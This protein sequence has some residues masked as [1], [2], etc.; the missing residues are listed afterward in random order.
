MKGC[1]N[2]DNLEGNIDPSAIIK[3]TSKEL[4]K[5]IEDSIKIYNNANPESKL[6]LNKEKE[7]KDVDNVFVCLYNDNKVGLFKKYTW[8]QRSDACQNENDLK[9]DE[10]DIY[11]G[12]DSNY[13]GVQRTIYAGLEFARWKNNGFKVNYDGIAYIANCNMENSMSFDDMRHIMYNDKKIGK[14]QYGKATSN[15]MFDVLSYASSY[16]NSS[17]YQKNKNK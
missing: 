7:L 2:K 4:L 14:F 11:I 8:R 17:K 10:G 13:I 3:E 1:I 9:I 15:E 5:S 6:I 12:I 16:Y